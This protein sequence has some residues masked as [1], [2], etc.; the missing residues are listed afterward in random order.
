M[1]RIVAAVAL[2]LAA[3]CAAPPPPEGL[4]PDIAAELARSGE[5]KPPARTDS[6][7]RALL[8]PVQ[9]GMPRVQGLELEP[10]FDLAV[11][12]APAACRRSGA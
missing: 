4:I 2:A 10:R 12:G 3:G 7:E 1:K 5:R 11:T 8:P 6:L 9:M